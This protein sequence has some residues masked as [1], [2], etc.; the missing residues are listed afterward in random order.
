MLIHAFEKVEGGNI[1]NKLSYFL[2]ASLQ[3]YCGDRADTKG[4]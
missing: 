2:R 4:I 3:K 1:R